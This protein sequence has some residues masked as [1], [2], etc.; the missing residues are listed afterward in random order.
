MTRD[1]VIVGGG[2]AGL[3]AAWHLRHRDVLLLEAGDRLGGRMRSDERG[4]YW[5][6]YGA[7]LFP[8]PG[9]LVDRITAECEL[10]TVPVTGGMMGLAVG[11]AILDGGRVESYPF[12]LPL[13]V[14]E[15]IAFARA[16]VKVQLAVRR[17]HAAANR[18]DFENDRSFADFLGPLPPK[19]HAIFSCAAHRATGEL[20]ELAAGAGIGLFAL[21][22]AGKGSLIAR[23]LRGGTGQLPAAMGRELGDRARTHARVEA[24]RADGDELAVSVNGEEVRA[25][26]VIMAANAPYASPLVGPVA[27]QAADALAKLTYGAFLSVAVETRETTAMPYDGVYAIA[28]PGRVF[29]MFTNQAHA[30]RVGPRTPG[31]SLMLFTGA[32][33]AAALMRE[34]D[35]VIVE[36]FLADLH[37]MYPQTRGVI[38]NATV[39]RWELGNVY[40]SPGRGA[41]QPALE[42]A[43]GTHENLH[44]AGDYFAEL[45]TMEAAAQTGLAAAE[46]VDSRIREAVNV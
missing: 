31:G 33:Q 16:G 2:I 35:E 13:S 46:R 20:D 25:R 26:H 29:D 42:G 22:W 15:R 30:L 24:V 6:N 34:S 37:A 32:Q 45:G 14:R 18:Y 38:A 36:R 44:L 5:L 39:Q 12:R 10:E 8:A 17:Y 28:T 40:A 4:D 21:V 23:N 3:S 27:P 41:L 7:H 19:V 43:L 9:T 1:V 11:D